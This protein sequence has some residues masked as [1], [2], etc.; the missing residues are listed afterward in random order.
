MLGNHVPNDIKNKSDINELLIIINLSEFL[1][2]IYFYVI[3][4]LLC[5]LDSLGYMWEHE[6]VLTHYNGSSPLLLYS[7]TSSCQKNWPSGI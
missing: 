3:D 2:Q 5:K 7:Q 6:I 4:L 1:R